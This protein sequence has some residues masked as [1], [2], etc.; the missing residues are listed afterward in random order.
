MPR[1]LT[2]HGNVAVTAYPQPGDHLVVA[3]DAAVNPSRNCYG[4]AFLATDGRYGLALRSLDRKEGDR[5]NEVC[6]LRAVYHALR[7][8]GGDGKI[9]VLMDAQD[10]VAQL[11]RWQEGSDGF[12]PGYDAGLR[13]TGKAKLVL[14]RD[15]VRAAPYRFTFTWT[16]GH[17]GHPL[18]EFA[19]SAAKLALRIGMGDVPRDDAKKVPG[20]WAE[21]RLG[22]WFTVGG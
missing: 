4:T 20:P 12:P 17:V 11:V 22:D 1:A 16:R 5:P 8:L 10:A 9:T 13:V 3:T 21:R 2:R 7:H 19:D 6:E 15:F 14:L 18:N